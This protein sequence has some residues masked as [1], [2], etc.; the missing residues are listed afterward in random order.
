M[1]AG[2]LPSIAV[3]DYTVTALSDGVLYTT[4]D[5]ILGIDKAESERLTGVKQGERLPLDV[6]CFLI[7]HG[8]R[9]MLSDAGSGLDL[10]HGHRAGLGRR[11]AVPRP[12]R[13]PASRG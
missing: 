1:N 11:P 4:P 8:D 3:G 5:V 6:N 12:R 13:R 7:R 2:P 10:R 9:L